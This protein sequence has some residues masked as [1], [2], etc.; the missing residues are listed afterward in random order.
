MES[1]LNDYFLHLIAQAPKANDQLI[2]FLRMVLESHH[3]AEEKGAVADLTAEVK[4]AVMRVA[5][6][7]RGLFALLSPKVSW[8]AGW[9]ASFQNSKI[10]NLQNVIVT[11]FWPLVI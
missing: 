5:S 10:Q 9:L 7:C 6:I 2:R 4:L 8:L 1:F 3:L 11:F